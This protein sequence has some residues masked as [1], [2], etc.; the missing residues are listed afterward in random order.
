MPYTNRLI[1]RRP[2]QPARFSGVVLVEI[3]NSTA[4]FDIER[5]WAESWRYLVRCGIAY[6]GITSKPNV[7]PQ[8]KRFDPTRYGALDWPNPCARTVPRPE[9]PQG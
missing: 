8:L 7:L 3:I 9:P 5:I 4:D 1:L 2:G 6:V